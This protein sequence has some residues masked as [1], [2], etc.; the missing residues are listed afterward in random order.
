MA[1]EPVTA[2]VRHVRRLVGAAPGRDTTDRELLRRFAAHH[3]EAAFEALLLRHGPMVLRVCRRV[4]PNAADAED[5]FQATFLVLARKAPS[6]F[7]HDSVAN[8]LYGVAQRLAHKAR[9]S[10][11]R[12]SAREARHAVR[13]AADP[14][15][16]ITGRE[17][18]GALDEELLRLPDKYREPLVLCY[19]QGLTRD[20]A[21]QRLG[22]PLGT[23]KARLERGRCLLGR[24]LTRRGIVP[25][26]ALAASLAVAGRGDA[27]PLALVRTTLHG[28]GAGADTSPAVRA[29]VESAALPSA[30]AA[31]VKAVVLLLVGLVT[32]GAALAARHRPPADPPPARAEAPA[33]PQPAREAVDA[34]GDPLPPGALMRLGTRRHRVPNWP[35]IWRDLPDGKSY[36]ICQRLDGDSEIR[37]LD[38]LTGRVLETCPVPGGHGV[39]GFSPDGRHVL[40]NTEFIYSSGIR[41]PGRGEKQEWVLILYDLERRKAVWSKS[42]RQEQGDWKSVEAAGFSSDGKWIATT[43]RFGSTL[44]LWDGTTGKELWHHQ[45]DNVTLTPLGFADDDRTLVVRRHEDNTIRLLDRATG[46]SLRSFSTLATTESQQCVLAPDG[47]AVLFGRYGPSVRVWDLATG[48]ERAPLEGHKAWA[49]AVAFSR[50]GKTVVTGGNDPFVLVRDWPSGQV[51]RTIATERERAVSQMAVSA[52]GRRLEVLF[53]GEQALH[54]YDLATGKPL[55]APLECHRGVVYRVA[56]APDGAL[57]SFG[58]DG[59][60][61]TW[62]LRARKAVGLLP[63]EQDLNAG[64]FALSRDG[65]LLAVSNSQENAVVLYERATGKAVRKLSAEHEEGRDLAFSP[66]A[67]WLAGV[68]CEGGR[69]RV[70][71]VTSGRTM[72]TLGGKP[73]AYAVRCAFS[74]DGRRF[75]SAEHGL[76]RFWDTNTWEEES[77]LEAYAPMGL[78]FSPDGRTLATASLEGVRLFELATHRE[79]AHI[80]PKGYPNGLLHF[81]H[82]GRWLAWMSDRKT[83]HVWDVR[84]GELV[85]PFAGHDSP[86]TGLDAPVTGLAFTADDRALASSSDDSTI[87]VWDVAGSASTKPLVGVADFE[88]AW[89][90][91]A[92]EDAKAAWTS[93]RDLTFSP[94]AVK[95]IAARLKPAA[96]I[97]PKR[98]AACLSDLDSEEFTVRERAAR[99]LEQMGERGIPALE[100]FLTGTPSPEAK[101]VV[102][103]VL[104]KVRGLVYDPEQL[105]QMRALEV[106]ERVGDEDARRVLE[107]L[108]GGAPEARSTREAKSA[109]ERLAGRP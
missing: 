62:D 36:L 85:G 92:G 104:E 88:P 87:L 84:R 11:V 76:V 99:E 75:A 95:G 103:A 31:K 10:A 50:D 86:A 45:Q 102:R 16:E 15:E 54:L 22:C 6:E 74:P 63:V 70:W 52:D 55:P 21:A 19:L 12:R 91:L 56:V 101:R 38:A 26:T 96:A 1:A 48:K 97:D 8:W 108:A 47:R 107:T 25:G 33:A 61:R 34:L 78:S 17:L 53:W 24:A 43:G 72:L 3:D 83:I 41:L 2:V 82:T 100:R 29:L 105:R 93:I 94:G 58:C 89:K 51:V 71:D 28:L 90:A 109:L 49:R 9:E 32:A 7:W 13:S 81:S 98:I 59:T 30:G 60:V 18:L 5:V 67:R 69:I 42:E 4:L 46:K 68:H 39:A 40:L 77:S 27:V 23:L 14:L 64:G 79:R 37:R 20:E 80:R 73:V 44:R 65:R 106:L 35:A 66:D 57:L